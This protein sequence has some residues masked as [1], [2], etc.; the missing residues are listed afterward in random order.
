VWK[1]W[2]SK[3]TNSNTGTTQLALFSQLAISKRKRK[4][5]C[6]GFYVFAKKLKKQVLQV[7]Y[8]EREMR[9]A[10]GRARRRERERRAHLAKTATIWGVLRIHSSSRSL[11]LFSVSLLLHAFHGNKL[12]MYVLKV[13]VCAGM[14]WGI[15]RI[16][17]KRQTKRGADHI[18]K[19][20]KKKMLQE[21]RNKILCDAMREALIAKNEIYHTNTSTVEAE[22]TQKM[23]K[24]CRC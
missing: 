3:T 2:L 21:Y 1:I 19:P 16:L 13:C 11:F 10:A 18:Q 15:L 9:V 22:K 4:E 6:T 23:G 24:T 7:L 8:Y 5:E 17:H 12:C 14:L 20:N